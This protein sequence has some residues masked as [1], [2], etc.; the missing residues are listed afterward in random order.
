MLCVFVPGIYPGITEADDKADASIQTINGSLVSDAIPP[1]NKDSDGIAEECLQMDLEVETEDNSF[2]L[3]FEDQL[4][5]LNSVSLEPVYKNDSQPEPS[6]SAQ[7]VSAGR[8]GRPLNFLLV[9]GKYIHKFSFCH[10]FFNSKFKVKSLNR[11]HRVRGFTSMKQILAE[12]DQSSNDSDPAIFI[13]GSP[14]LTLIRLH[15]Q[16]VTLALLCSTSI[17]EN[18][19]SQTEINLNTLTSTVAKVK[20]NGDLLLLLPSSDQQMAMGLWVWNGGYLKSDS[21]IPNTNTSTCKVVEVSVHGTLIEPVDP[22]VVTASL[23]LAV[24]HCAEIN[25]HDIT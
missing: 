8:G 7:P 9:E 5:T 20:V 6:N 19:V 4:K 2:V 16:T 22:S 10:I 13:T 12:P 1:I 24:E 21:P 23:H 11:L 17:V 14:F 3:D 18:G 15:D 25:S